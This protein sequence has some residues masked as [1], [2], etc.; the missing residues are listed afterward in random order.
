MN[1]QPRKL[2]L[3]NITRITPLGCCNIRLNMRLPP[4]VTLA[5]KAST[6]TPKALWSAT[7]NNAARLGLPDN[8]AYRLAAGGISRGSNHSASMPNS[9]GMPLL[10]GWC[11]RGIPADLRCVERALACARPDA[12]PCCKGHCFMILYTLKATRPSEPVKYCTRSCS[13]FS[14]DLHLKLLSRW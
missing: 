14:K 13:V 4:D 6:G 5:N 7:I 12:W 1:W 3:V 9:D 10:T 8:N 11:I 2:K